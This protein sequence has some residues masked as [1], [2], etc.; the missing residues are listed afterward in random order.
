MNLSVMRYLSHEKFDMLLTDRGIF[1]APA[2]CQ[3]DENEGKYSSEIL[4]EA[5]GVPELAAGLKDTF[6]RSMNYNRTVNF[7]SSWYIGERESMEMWESYGKNGVLIKS[8]AWDLR[9]FIPSPLAFGAD[10]HCVR[11]SDEEKNRAFRVPLAN[12]EEKFAEE[13]E[14]RIVF[15]MVRYKCQ[16][17][18]ETDSSLLGEGSLYASQLEQGVF[19]PEVAVTRNTALTRK[20]PGLIFHYDLNK[21]ISEIVVYPGASDEFMSDI[22]KKCQEAVLLC[23]VI[24]SK[25]Q[26]G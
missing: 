6:D 17:G 26:K 5:I 24:P 20:P 3:S 21:I 4:V 11:Y 22:K 12:K 9:A 8:K 10:F 14:F 13:N 16:T 19:G 18:Y 15:D 23:E 25:L 7:L 1:L 2:G